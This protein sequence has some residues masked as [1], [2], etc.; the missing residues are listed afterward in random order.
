MGSRSGSIGSSW[1]VVYTLTLGVEDEEGIGGIR[2]LWGV[3]VQRDSSLSCKLHVEIS[4]LFSLPLPYQLFVLIAM[5]VISFNA[6]L[7]DGISCVIACQLWP[8]IHDDDD[9]P[10]PHV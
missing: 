5:S 2:V 9:I 10:A 8:K 1:T 3:S 4:T 6:L 7:W